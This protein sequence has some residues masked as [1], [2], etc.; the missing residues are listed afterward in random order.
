MYHEGE[1]RARNNDVHHGWNIY[2]TYGY[3]MKFVESDHRVGQGREADQQVKNG[4]GKS[5]YYC[6]PIIACIVATGFHEPSKRSCR[7][8]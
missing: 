4:E 5:V 3:M 7:V 8:Q 2:I 6:K 1:S